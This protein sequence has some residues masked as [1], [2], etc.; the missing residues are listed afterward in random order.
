M[1]A[2]EYC[3]CGAVLSLW[4]DGDTFTRQGVEHSRRACQ[5]GV[6]AAEDPVSPPV[7]VNLRIED[8]PELQ[9]ILS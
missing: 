9:D 8:D 7:S 1:T 5:R 2:P 3:R 6:Y 4:S